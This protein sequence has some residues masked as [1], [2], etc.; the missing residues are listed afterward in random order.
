MADFTSGDTKYSVRE[1][2]QPRATY[3]LLTSSKL[4]SGTTTTAAI[5]TRRYTNAVLYTN[6]SQLSGTAG[7]TLNVEMQGSPYNDENWFSLVSAAARTTAGKFVQNLMS[8]TYLTNWTR[9]NIFYNA[10]NDGGIWT[11]A[12]INF[13][14]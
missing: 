14:R 12:D 13:I 9:A 6:I 4:L 11:T 2:T 7:I 3:N 1:A 5:D 8:G 10:S